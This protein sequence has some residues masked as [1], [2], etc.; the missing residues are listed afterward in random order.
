MPPGPPEE[1]K[2]LRVVVTV[3]VCIGV[4]AAAVQDAVPVW[5]AAVALPAL[6][7]AALVAHRHRHGA[8]GWVKVVAAVIV[9]LALLRAMGGAAQIATLDEARFTLAE[10][11]VGVQVA[12]A[13]DLPR[14]R[15]LYVSLGSSLVLLAVAASLS[16]DMR[17]GVFLLLWAVSALSALVLAHRSSLTE[18]TIGVVTSAPQH[19]RSAAPLARQVARGVTIAA[20]AGATVFLV[21]PP[22]TRG[23]TLALPF[24]VGSGGGTPGGG[25]LRQ[26]ASADDSGGRAAGA[27]YHG[28]STRM[29]LRVRGE[30]PDELVMRVQSSAP[31]MWRGAVFDTYDGIFWLGDEERGRDLSA[32]P[33]YHLPS[34]ATLGPRVSISQTYFLEAEL[35]TAIYGVGEP[36][37]VYFPSG[38]AID[39]FG[40]PRSEATLDDG[41]VYSVVSSY[42][43]ASPAELRTAPSVRPEAMGSGTPFAQYLQLPQVPLRVAELARRVTAGAT[44]DYDRVRAI[45]AHLR[46]TYPYRLDSA[47]PPEG[48]DAV[49]HF[50]FDAQE[51]FCEQFAAAMTVMA[52][53]LGIAARVATGY[54]PGSYN[55]LTGYY[56]VRGTDAHAWVEV[57]HPRFGWYPY[58][59]TSSVPAARTSIL[60][61]VP[62]VRLVRWFAERARSL[63]PVGRVATAALA[64]AAVALGLR[65][66]RRRRRRDEPDVDPRRPAPVVARGPATAA[67][68]R[69]DVALSARGSPRRTWETP[70]ELLGRTWV[71][72]AAATVER[73]AYAVQPPDEAESAAAARLI[74]EAVAVV[75]AESR[76]SG[77]L[78]P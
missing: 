38:I 18:G 19:G 37:T 52:R 78:R 24:K 23:T 66:W 36:A 28:V 34:R 77:R 75:D 50:L 67:L 71:T 26:P 55:A 11:F 22:P 54:V 31:G 16:Q 5:L 45:E 65:W 9:P 6:P 25:L 53:T 46:R 70:A 51:G 58:D 60:D 27:S 56:S 48:Q 49:D 43:A 63:E 72:A 21:V 61:R 13:L 64:A 57:Y 4:L 2:A 10:L 30:L 74:D 42:G 76:G 69:L 44:N 12:H 41:L 17:F 68:A 1:S 33:I 62:A 14:R 59:P 40:L 73:E 32:G 47:V 39:R 35:S 8:P 7:A 20:V 29:D 15:D 3:A